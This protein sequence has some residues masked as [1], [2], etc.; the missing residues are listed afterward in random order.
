MANTLFSSFR[1]RFQNDWGLFLILTTDVLKAILNFIPKKAPDGFIFGFNLLK[2]KKQT[3]SV[4]RLFQPLFIMASD[5][6]GS[7]SISFKGS[8]DE[9]NAYKKESQDENL[10]FLVLRI[11]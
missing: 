3:P 2:C 1:F 11:F 6:S 7:N 8:D 10:F 5:I 9:K 4:P